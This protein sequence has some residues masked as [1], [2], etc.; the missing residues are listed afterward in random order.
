LQ[1]NF[2]TNQQVG[3]I[4]GKKYETITYKIFPS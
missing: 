2:V 4:Y 3:C 1:F